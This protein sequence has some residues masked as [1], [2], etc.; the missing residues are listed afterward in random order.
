MNGI[1][2]AAGRGSRLGSHTRDI[3]KCLVEL[4]GQPL[5]EWQ[6]AALAVAGAQ[7]VVVVRGYRPE[8][9]PGDGYPTADNPRWAETNM[10]GSLACAAEWL[11]RGPAIVSYADIVYH[12][13]IVWSLTNAPGDIC[14]TYDR[15][16]ARLWAERFADPL[17]DAESFVVRNGQVVSIG[18]RE[19]SIDEI[20]GQYMGLLKFTPAGWASVERLLD[21]LPAPERDRLDM[22]SLLRRLI[23]AG[24]PVQGVPVDGRWCEVDSGDGP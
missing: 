9:L 1:V 19:D 14:I 13:S 5:L 3:P 6:R 17:S 7:E 4:A 15:L 16:W 22:T 21:G 8:C 23:A 24:I 12:P 18:E 20:Q 11:C 2:L 10:V